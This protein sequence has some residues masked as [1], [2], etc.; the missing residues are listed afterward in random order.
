VVAS[1]DA[2]GDLE[3]DDISSADLAEAYLESLES[4][5]WL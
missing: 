2:R 1:L 3:W 4:V 5:A